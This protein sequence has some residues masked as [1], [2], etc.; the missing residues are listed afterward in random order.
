MACIVDDIRTIDRAMQSRRWAQ[1]GSSLTGNP[2]P[3]RRPT[4]DLVDANRP[5]SLNEGPLADTS[6]Q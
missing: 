2:S 1:A 4:D 3:S 5:L 6:D